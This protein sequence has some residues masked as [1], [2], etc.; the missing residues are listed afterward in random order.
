LIACFRGKTVTKVLIVEDDA[1]LT[2]LLQAQLE[3]L[4]YEVMDIASSGE[5]AI[6]ITEVSQPD[7][8][9]MDIMMPGKY[10]GI[11]AA[12][13]IIKK[14]NTPIIFLT[15]RSDEEAIS[16]AK[17]VKPYGYLI[18]PVK[19]FDIKAAIEMA[20]ARKDLEQRLNQSEAKY[21][22][23]I[24]DQT[25]LICRFSCEKKLTFAN[26][27][28]CRHFKLDQ[29]SITDYPFAQATED[30]ELPNSI[31][32]PVITRERHLILADG[33][34]NW[35][36]WTDRAIFNDKNEIIEYQSVGAD[37]TVL[38]QAEEELK[39][40]R[41]HLQEMVDEQTRDLRIAKE[42]AEEANRAKSEFL[43]NMSHELRTPLHGILSFSQLGI[44]KTGTIPEEK[45]LSY[46]SKIE[47]SGNRLLALLNNLLD[48][49]QMEAGITSYQK[50]N[51][52]LLFVTN[53]VVASYQSQLL[54]RKQKI[55]IQQPDIPTKLICDSFRIEQLINNLI[56]N[57]I[58]FSPDEK[59]IFIHFEEGTALVEGETLPVVNFAIRDQGVGIPEN[60]LVSVFEKF[61]QSSRTNTGAG[62]V[63]LG[64]AICREIVKAHHGSIRAENHPE[65]G[66][67]FSFAL[68]ISQIQ[69]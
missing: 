14:H 50:S 64:L 9:L 68:P 21:R 56:S 36:Q 51:S 66:A 48:L 52:D 27:A 38:K 2:T 15:A 31:E 25:E 23:V 3:R 45:I 58:R 43:A 69:S 44:T 6:S 59:E 55:H 30:N 32:N 20:M 12:D 4:D 22:A 47:K 28:F 26:K 35:Y 65:G 34:T 42:K 46:F 37:I 40:H 53:L 54:A 11:Q 33:R 13:I 24:E 5:Q 61:S 1:V 29:E 16:Q 8:I 63:G 7:L 49:S 67:V 19:I 57:A 39:Q 41:N 60:E 62:G 18:K 10:N 17:E